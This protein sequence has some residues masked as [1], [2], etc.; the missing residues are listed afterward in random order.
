MRNFSLLALLVPNLIFI[1]PKK[2]HEAKPINRSTGF[3]VNWYGIHIKADPAKRYLEANVSSVITLNEESNTVVWDF[4]HVLKVDSILQGKKKL[5]FAQNSNNTLVVELPRKAMAGDRVKMDIYYSGKPP[6]T[7]IADNDKGYAFITTKHKGQPILFIVNEPYGAMQWWPNRNTLDDK[8]DSLDFFITH[9]VQYKASANGLLM[10]ENRAGD[11]VTTHFSHAYPI[12]SYLVAF[13]ISNYRV[14]E[15]TVVIGSK[16]VPIITYA[17]PE[18][19]AEFENNLDDLIHAMEMFSKIFGEYPFINECYIQTQVSGA[20]GMEHQANS[21]VDESELS[22]Q[23]HELAHQW[24]GD[25]VTHNAWS[26]LWLKEGAADYCADYLY[27]T[28]TGDNEHAREN[29]NDWLKDIT[30]LPNGMVWAKDS[31]N[32]DKLFGD[33]LTYSKPAMIYRMLH[34]TVGDTLFYY[35]LRNYLND[36][37]LAYGFAGTKQLQE[38]FE[39][40]SGKSLDYFFD[41]WVYGEGQPSIKLQWFQRKDKDLTVTLSQKTSH[42]SIKFFKMELPVLLKGEGAEKF[43]IIILDSNKMKVTI[44]DPGFL[45]EEIEIDP[46]HWFITADNEVQKNSLLIP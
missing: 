1:Q 42:E 16:K 30:K 44:A 18:S 4:T 3:H 29:V 15:R 35:A 25:K 40:A 32:V 41:Q 28:L 23:N 21:F 37:E 9:P 13:A 46:E 26:S 8:A 2:I 22:L 10:S 27:P 17:Y 43:E 19:V 12:A 7:K 6:K 34:K 31:T 24:F 39:K 5:S 38:H 14:I 20:G 33:R 45:V 11:Y 36:P